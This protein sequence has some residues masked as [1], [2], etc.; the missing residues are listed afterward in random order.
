[1]LKQNAQMWRGVLICFFLSACSKP[2]PES[3]ADGSCTDPAFPFCDSDGSVAGTPDKCIAVSCT[4]SQFETC[5]GDDAIVCNAEGTNFDL[6]R[7]E[8]GCVDPI[9]CRDCASNANCTGTTP[10]CDSETSSCRRCN[11]D[12]EC[13]SKVCDLETGRCL[14]ESSVVYTSPQA[15]DNASCS[16]TQPCTLGTAVNRALSNPLRS[17][18]LMLPGEYRGNLSIINGS[19][20]IVGP[21]AFLEGET[22]GDVLRVGNGA[23]V[24]V[25]GVDFDLLS[26]HL[27]CDP[28]GGSQRPTMSLQN[29]VVHGSSANHL[30]IAA[31]T[32]FIRSSEFRTTGAYLLAAIRF[33]A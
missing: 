33:G 30:R 22:T 6:V 13:A 23:N 12:S 32:A 7:C 29:V 15:V 17:T 26:G 24:T 20:T 14:A 28:N 5:R 3:C 2:N 4:A 11:D 27:I 19:I 25:R 10:V 16:L 21:G 9:G 18:V 31:C 1:M 8:L